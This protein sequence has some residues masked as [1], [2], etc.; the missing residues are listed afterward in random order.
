MSITPTRIEGRYLT[1]DRKK[2][3]KRKGFGLKRLVIASVSLLMVSVMSMAQAETEGFKHT[4]SLGVT[5]TDG[6]SETLQANAALITEGEKDGLGSVRAGVEANYGESTVDGQ[7]ETTIENAR[8]LAN[9][10]KT[11]SPRTFASLDGSLLYDDIAA[12]DYRG[13]IAPGVGTYLVKND[14]TAL[15]FETGPAYVW[16][17]V[18]D[19]SDDYFALRLAQRL[20]H[21]LSPTARMWQSAEYLPKADDFDDYLLNAEIGVEAA[22]N[23]RVNLRLVLQNKYDSTPAMGLKKND[24][25]LIAG[26]GVSL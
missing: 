4:L 13:I 11:I 3:K 7:T 12:I 2:Q 23:A 5:L 16:E 10:K 18:A 8:L 21:V 9:V 6:N 25:T 19:I 20:D 22:V 15:Y 14:S 17:K 1:I 24:L 26:I